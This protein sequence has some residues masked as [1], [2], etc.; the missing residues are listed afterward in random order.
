MRRILKILY[1][2][3][4]VESVFSIDYEKIYNRGYKA[5]IFDIDNTLV[6]HGKDATPE[7][8]ELIKQIQQIGF[9]VLFL[10]NNTEDRVKSFMKN[11]DCCLYINDAEK[12]KREGYL[13]AIELLNEDKHNI[14]YIGDQLF[15]DIYGANKCGIDSI[16]VKYIGYYKKD[17]KGIKRNIEKILLKKYN[18]NKR[19]KN[20]LGNLEKTEAIKNVWEK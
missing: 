16:L 15:T 8:E 10:S 1:P 12:P 18:N 17:K 20:R 4:Y 6:P 11:M 14:I 2:C 3:E 5:L 9:K 19:Y 7:I 13:K